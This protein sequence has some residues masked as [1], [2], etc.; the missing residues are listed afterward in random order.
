[1]QALRGDRLYLYLGGLLKL[2]DL[3]DVT[4]YRA[5]AAT[6]VIIPGGRER[7]GCFRPL[8]LIRIGFGGDLSYRLYA[9]LCMQ[10]SQLQ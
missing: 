7:H 8:L 9:S 10:P 4:N 6:D 1:M 2:F 5:V 3:M